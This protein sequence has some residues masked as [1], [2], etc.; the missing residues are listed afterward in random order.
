MF[1]SS[2]I[3]LELEYVFPFFITW[4]LYVLYVLLELLVILMFYQIIQNLDP[5]KEYTIAR[6][7]H[8]T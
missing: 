7:T 6:F 8:Q 1:Q 3:V 4:L 5:V 2:F